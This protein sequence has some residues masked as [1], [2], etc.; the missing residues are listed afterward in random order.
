MR[1]IKNGFTLI[2]LMGVLLVIALLLILVTPNV[3]R[4]IE[5]S[6][7]NSYNMIIENAKT[8]A[9]NYSQEC[10][11]GTLASSNCMT[12]GVE[13]DKKITR[14]NAQQLVDLGYLKTTEYT[15]DEKTGNRKRYLKDPRSN[16]TSKDLGECLVITITKDIKTNISEYNVNNAC[17]IKE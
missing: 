10:M 1:R 3:Q 15:T 8:G 17:D 16:S 9:K 4:F 5:Y 13:G 11:L 14:F 2:E 6:E 12:W 7:E